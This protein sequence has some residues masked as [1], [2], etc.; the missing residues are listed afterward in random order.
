MSAAPIN[1][2]AQ[3]INPS[4]PAYVHNTTAMPLQGGGSPYYYGEGGGPHI[5]VIPVLKDGTT[6]LAA[7]LQ[8]R[9]GMHTV[10]KLSLSEINDIMIMIS[11][12]EV[13]IILDRYGTSLVCSLQL[14][15]TCLVKP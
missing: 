11:C 1:N 8:T 15:K 14:A 12:I 7:T 4:R 13:C 10:A 6:C 3:T 9:I 2:Y 5:I